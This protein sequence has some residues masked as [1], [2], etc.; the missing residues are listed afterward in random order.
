MSKKQWQPPTKFG[1]SVEP[2]RP[3]PKVRIHGINSDSPLGQKILD[4]LSGRI[5]Q[6]HMAQ[7][8]NY[9]LAPQA[10]FRRRR[11]DP[12]VAMMYTNQFGQELIEVTV[13][14]QIIE[15]IETVKDQ[16]V[17][18]DVMVVDV[19]YYNAGGWWSVTM[20]GSEPTGV[21]GFESLYDSQGT[22]D[23]DDNRVRFGSR[24]SL[25]RP[26][27]QLFDPYR[28]PL[29]TQIPSQ[30]TNLNEEYSVS[31]GDATQRSA[32][33]DMRPS[34]PAPTR[35]R[36]RLGAANLDTSGAVDVTVRVRLYNT[37]QLGCVIS[38]NGDTYTPGV[39]VPWSYRI[40]TLS[41]IAVGTGDDLGQ[42]ALT[43]PPIRASTDVD[44][45]QVPPIFGDVV[46]D[47]KAKRVTFERV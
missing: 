20:G 38:V 9:S 14:P 44:T 43:T 32:A 35:V 31:A 26:G 30:Q 3:L 37:T 17:L 41:S 15:S 1:E 42:I 8:H 5:G 22:P 36:L 19:I 18:F 10:V 24:F 33:V 45:P 40:V 29:T 7:A 21:S 23:T 47:P 27:D 13:N 46:Y 2:I 34:G 39:G 6:F 28:L 25:M 12:D 16:P 11:V 4:A